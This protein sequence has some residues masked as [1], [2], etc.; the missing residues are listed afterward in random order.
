MRLRDIKIGE[1][2]RH[3]DH[4]GYAWARVIRIIPPHTIANPRS[5]ALV[6]C[7]WG[8]NKPQDTDTFGIIKYFR[9]SD[10]VK[11]K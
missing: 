11:E 7:E 3:K 10:L 5:Y 6:V 8:V 4:Q 1:Y 2:Y 9:A